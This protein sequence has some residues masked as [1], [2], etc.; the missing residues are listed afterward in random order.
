VH[1]KQPAEPQQGDVCPVKYKNP[2]IFN[3]YGQKIDPSNMMPAQA[4]QLPSAGQEKA[5]PTTRVV[6][7]IAKG[8]TDDTW[9][10]PSEQMFYNSLKR[11]GKGADVKEDDVSMMVAIHNNMNERTWRDLLVWERMHSHECGDPRLLR[12]T[13]RPDE[14][15]PKARLRMLTGQSEPFDR[16]DWV[17]D[18]CGREVR[19]IIDYYHDDTLPIDQTAPRQHDMNAKTQIWVD[20]RPALDSPGALWDRLR[21]TAM[22]AMGQTPT[23]PQDWPLSAEQ[24]QKQGLGPAGGGQPKD[25]SK[26]QRAFVNKMTKITDECAG[27]L[28]ALS[29][30]QGEEECEKAMLRKDVCVAQIACPK[31]A[32][33]FMKALESGKGIEAAHEK[34]LECGAKLTQESEKLFPA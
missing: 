18:R 26:E 22:Q 30:C 12:F 6:S 4:Q 15:S 3:V 31:V 16:H 5:L 25:W 32:A 13:G 23:A 20:V 27:T 14:L 10:Y 17:V 11:K 7:G 8:G 2:S 1:K 34:V 19:Y 24:V 29:T 21:L 9:V 28:S 33:A